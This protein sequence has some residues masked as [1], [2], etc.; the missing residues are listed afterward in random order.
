[1]APRSGS[2][3]SSSG[4]SKEAAPSAGQPLT[5]DT[6]CVH[7]KAT[8]NLG[9]LQCEALASRDPGLHTVL[10]LPL[11][12]TSSR[13]PRGTKHHLCTLQ[14]RETSYKHETRQ[15]PLPLQQDPPNHSPAHHEDS[16]LHSTGAGLRDPEGKENTRPELQAR[17]KS[18]RLEGKGLAG[19]WVTAPCALLVH[20]LPFSQSHLSSRLCT[21]SVNQDQTPGRSR[22]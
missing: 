20:S 8:E 13:N 6:K 9:R 10:P 11:P 18:Q 4:K 15:G 16:R 17:P 21:Q 7:I 1:M 12:R 14:T 19:D 3:T 2:E 22:D 5:N